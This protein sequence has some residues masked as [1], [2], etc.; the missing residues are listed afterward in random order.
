MKPD[1]LGYLLHAVEPEEAHH[2]EELL[3]ANPQW[4]TEAVKIRAALSPL[5]LLENST[6]SDEL[7]YQTLRAV[8]TA[9]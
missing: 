9:R 8:T 4:R 5:E 6:P 7:I 1:L 2:L 3:E